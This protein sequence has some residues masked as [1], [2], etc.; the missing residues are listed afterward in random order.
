MFIFFSVINILVYFNVL[1]F[2]LW[3]LETGG[4]TLIFCIVMLINKKIERNNNRTVTII[5]FS[6]IFIWGV[7]LFASLLKNIF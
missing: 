7:T 1:P 2:I 3:R 6:T 4:I 5:S